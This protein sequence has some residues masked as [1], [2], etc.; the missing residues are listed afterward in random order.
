MTRPV[1]RHR[2]QPG[3][4][5]TDVEP[6]LGLRVTSELAHAARRRQAEYITQARED[7][8]TWEQIGSA[9]GL[10]QRP[11]CS[12]TV[13]EL[14]YDH[15]TGGAAGFDR[16]SFAWV[17]PACRRTVLD[18][19][20]DAGHPADCEEGHASDCPHLADAT[21]AWNASRQEDEQ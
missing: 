4:V 3:A 5:L 17:C 15:A 10:G 20:P 8:C 11:D 13:A 19:G 12:A 16:R 18:R 7:G 21:A 1:F 14:A 9:L 2:P 6:L